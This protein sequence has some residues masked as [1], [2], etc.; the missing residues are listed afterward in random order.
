MQ[1]LTTRQMSH[2]SCLPTTPKWG[3]FVMRGDWHIDKS[4]SVGHMVTTLALVGMLVAT[5]SQM[6][7]RIETQG[8]QIEAIDKRIDRENVRQAE[9]MRQIRQS[10]N[11]IEDRL[12]R[13]A[14]Q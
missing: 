6:N 1:S 5:W 4:I 11:R 14:G 13:M 9:E 12:E 10:L 3:P 7:T 8:V 2:G